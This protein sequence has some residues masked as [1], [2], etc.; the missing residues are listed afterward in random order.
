MKTCILMASPRKWGNTA[1]L[2]EPFTNEL[3]ICGIQ[4]KTIY[5]YDQVILPCIGCKICQDD[6][7]NF[8]CPLEDDV[9]TIFDEIL[10][11]DMLV[12]ATPIYAWYCTAPMKALLDRLAYGM[13]KYYGNEK[14]P[15]LWSGKK[16]SMITTCGYPPE[17]GSD[18]FQVGI[19]RYCKHSQLIFSGVISEHDRGSQV[20]F[21]D[22]EKE[23]GVRNLARSFNMALPR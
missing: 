22:E 9:Q 12:L 2:L 13:N 14:G 18:I 15:S 7:V 19:E 1:S 6:W 5:L 23:R 17:K 21:M 3:S 8:G 4:H 20:P 10:S 11:C 16:L